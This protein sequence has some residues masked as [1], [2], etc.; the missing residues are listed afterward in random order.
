MAEQRYDI[1]R[2]TSDRVERLSTGGV[3]IPA[4]LTRV[5]VFD[6]RQADGTVRRELRP[7]ESVF[8]QDSLDSLKDAPVLD[9]HPAMVTSANYRELTRGNVSGVPKPEG[10]FVSSKLTVQDAG[11]VGLIDSGD[12]SEISCGYTCDVE[13][14][15]GVFDGQPY[16]CIQRNIRYN[17][18]GLG[19]KNWGRAGTDVALRLDSS[20]YIDSTGPQPENRK[21]VKVRFDG[22]EYEHGSDE[23]I[24]ALN[25]KLDCQLL[26]IA[27]AGQ[28]E[29]TRADK[30]DA[31]LVAEKAA[32]AKTQAELVTA[33]DRTKF[34]SAV[35][36][37]VDLLVK[38][39][40]AL[41]ADAK[42]DGKSDLE[43][44]S[45][46]VKLAY[47]AT[48]LDGRSV[49]YVSALFD[50]AIESGTRADSITRL[51]E[52]LDRVQVEA[53]A[54]TRKD[55]APKQDACYTHKFAASK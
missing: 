2:L 9:G 55:A 12:R 31:D 45:E 20:T 41:G 51:P 16:D 38:A 47:P 52:V 5:G 1:S 24:L 3:R 17:H 39:Q 43:V 49:D 7:A 46:V 22:K 13:P 34:D 6:Y 19:P 29:R 15:S 26:E 35:N 42:F 25:A 37:R 36:A 32:H 8:D 11:L 4:N 54:K 33:T 50:R 18:V 28:A 40:G 21:I 30:L 48:K 10:K 14:T 44:M 27:G 53:E 23:H